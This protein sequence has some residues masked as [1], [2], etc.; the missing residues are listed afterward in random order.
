MDAEEK[1]RLKEEL[2]RRIALIER[3]DETPIKRMTPRDYMMTG[4]VILSCL[5]AVVGGY[6][7]A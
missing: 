3:Q 2:E 1:T 6:F 4:A 5:A 7:L